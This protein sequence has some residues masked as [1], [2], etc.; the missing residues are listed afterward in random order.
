MRVVAKA[1]DKAGGLDGLSYGLLKPLPEAGFQAFVKV[2]TAANSGRDLCLLPKNEDIERPITLTSIT[3]RLYCAVKK[4][5]VNQW[6]RGTSHLCP[7]DKAVPV[8]T[9][10]E[11]GIL[12]LLRGA[13]ARSTPSRCSLTS[14]HRHQGSGFL[15]PAIRSGC[16]RCSRSPG[17]Q[18]WVRSQPGKAN[19]ALC[20]SHRTYRPECVRWTWVPETFCKKVG[21]DELWRREASDIADKVCGDFTDFT[22]TRNVIPPTVAEVKRRGVPSMPGS[23]HT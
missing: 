19:A 23:W 6:L 20:S 14:P 7:W 8:G 11:V 18:R 22:A 12:R 1:S 3:Y 21:K 2:L 15:P 5:V 4:E 9:C 17:S 16:Q 10:L 13:S